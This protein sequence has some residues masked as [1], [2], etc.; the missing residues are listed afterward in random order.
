MADTVK[1]ILTVN[2]VIDNLSESGLP[3]GEPEINIFTTDGTLALID[4]GY[5]IG[6]TEEQEGG[7]A[8]TDLY[9]YEDRVR[10]VKSGAIT[11]EMRFAEGE[12]F[13]TLY[14]VGP[15]SFDMSVRTKRIRNTV[16]DEGG[17]LQLIYTMNVGGQEKSVRMKIS[18]KRK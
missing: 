10:L 7:S 6:F 2:S 4:G 17:E 1:L 9:V 11:S 3:E 16:T 8:H 18:S 5:L 14:C 12:V 13:N 15:Y